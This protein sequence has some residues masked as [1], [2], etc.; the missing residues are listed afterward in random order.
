MLFNT[1][2]ANPIKSAYE[3]LYSKL[4]PESGHCDTLEG[5]LIRAISNI[6]WDY[7]ENA[8]VISNHTGA[9]KFIQA[10]LEMNDNTKHDISD[11]YRYVKAGYIPN[12]PIAEQ[13]DRL[14]YTITKHVDSKNDDTYTKG[15]YNFMLLQENDE[16]D[17]DEFES[18]EDKV[19]L[20]Y[21]AL[22]PQIFESNGGKLHSHQYYKTDKR[23][24]SACEYKTSVNE[25]VWLKNHYV[26][27]VC[28]LPGPK[29]TWLG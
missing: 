25:T 27:P 2:V 8:G 1:Q 14:A 28:Q 24:I 18:D 4:V 12:S 21:V 10:N 13:L 6:Y 26:Y 9:C 17:I 11:V 7:Q 15:N 29:G 5:E 23:T 3:K 16:I 19:P 22:L 20:Y